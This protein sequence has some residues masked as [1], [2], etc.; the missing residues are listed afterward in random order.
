M[1]QPAAC[2]IFY[3]IIAFSRVGVTSLH[4][5]NSCVLPLAVN[6]AERNPSF[7]REYA[8][9]PAAVGEMR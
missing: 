8:L 3:A 2:V 9:S 6:Y 4:A 7:R 1:G 5:A